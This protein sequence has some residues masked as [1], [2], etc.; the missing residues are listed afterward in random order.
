MKIDSIV[1]NVTINIDGQDVEVPKGTN[2]IEAVKMITGYPFKEST[3]K[4]ESLSSH[5][6]LL[7]GTSFEEWISFY[8]HDFLILNIKEEG[9]EKYVLDILE[10]HK[11]KDFFFLDQSFPFILKTINSG[12]KRCAIR[13]SEFESI[14]SAYNLAG[15]IEWVWIDYFNK[16][17]LNQKDFIGL[18]KLGYKICIVSPEIQ[19]KETYEIKTLKNFLLKN[20]II[21]DAVCT[22]ELDMWG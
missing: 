17:P 11:V 16:F 10:K 12:E 7:N 8:E 14:D 4:F 22:R 13:I 1:E 15:R 9:L 18:K 19:G 21:P 20:K 6:P 3:N 2:I 5:E